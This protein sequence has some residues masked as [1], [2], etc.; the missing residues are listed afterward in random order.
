MAF[1]QFLA[2]LFDHGRVGVVHP[3]EHVATG[4]VRQAQRLLED[5]AATVAL[6]FPG[7]PP[8]LDLPVATWAAMMLYRACQLAIYRELDAGAIGELLSSACP[9]AEASSRHYSAD[10]AFV[11]LPDLIRHATTAA[12]DDP[13][14]TR[15]RDLAAA[16]PLSSVGVAKIEPQN[17]AEIASHPGLLRLYVDRI[18]ARKDWPRLAERAVRAAAEQSLGAHSALWPEA[19]K[20][21]RAT[22]P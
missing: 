16:W 10:L 1:A 22:A 15:L 6:E 12:A 5:R 21:L 9:S 3:Q 13:L 2:A 14:V 8:R 7:Q 18:L 4:D 11:F 17:V 19:A 20:H